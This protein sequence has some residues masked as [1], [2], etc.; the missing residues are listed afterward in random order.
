MLH[1]FSVHLNFADN[2]W[3]QKLDQLFSDGLYKHHQTRHLDS[4][5]GTAGTGADKH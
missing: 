4:A 5:A 2:L 3:V 1:H